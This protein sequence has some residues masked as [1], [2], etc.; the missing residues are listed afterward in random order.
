MRL[1][2]WKIGF[3]ILTAVSAVQ[4]EIISFH[5]VYLADTITLN[6]IVGEDSLEVVRNCKK[7]A[8]CKVICEK[9]GSFSYSSEVPNIP[10]DCLDLADLLRCWINQKSEEM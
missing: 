10:T 4:V 6:A 9:D 1:K 8:D 5:K 7:N 3:Y 2:S